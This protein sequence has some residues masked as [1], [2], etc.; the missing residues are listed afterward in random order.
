MAEFAEQDNALVERLQNGDPQAIDEIVER[1]KRP[2]F[3]FILRMVDDYYTAEDLFQETWLRAVRSIRRFRGDSRFSTWL[4]QIAVNLCRDW[5]RS[6]TGRQFVPFEDIDELS[7]DPSVDPVRLLQSEAVRKLVG[8][9]PDKMREVIVLR[10]FHDMDD[11]EIARVVGCPV[12]T[13]KTRGYRAIKILSKKWNLR[14]RERGGE[15]QN[16]ILR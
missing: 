13:V 15:A 3:A 9:L 1:Y 16:E 8:E 12:A 10:Y 4:F 11:P 14:S 7:C 6:K 5:I 2:L